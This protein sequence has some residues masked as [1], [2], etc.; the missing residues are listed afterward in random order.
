[1]TEKANRRRHAVRRKRPKRL[2]EPPS[3]ER[4]TWDNLR[5]DFL[6]RKRFIAPTEMNQATIAASQESSTI[7]ASQESSTIAASQ[8]SSTVAA[9]QE[10]STM[11]ASQESST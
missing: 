4:H 5:G 3:V 10:S 1:M 6:R 2:Y 11:A 7:A 8:E 9:S